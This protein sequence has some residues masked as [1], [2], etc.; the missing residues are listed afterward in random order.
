MRRALTE[1]GY[2]RW[3]HNSHWRWGHGLGIG[4]H[5]V[6]PCI[7]PEQGAVRLATWVDLGCHHVAEFSRMGWWVGSGMGIHH[8]MEGVEEMLRREEK[9]ERKCR[10]RGKAEFRGVTDALRPGENEGD[11][12]DNVDKVT[13]QQTSTTRVTSTS[14]SQRDHSTTQTST[15][16]PDRRFFDRTVVCQVVSP[17]PTRTSNRDQRAGSG[18]YGEGAKCLREW[19]RMGSRRDD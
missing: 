17:H 10:E 9:R 3:W 18:G 1:G 12:D 11:A 13:E 6:G 2:H 16:A 8:G 4:T 5:R 19:R 7:H 14:P 15:R